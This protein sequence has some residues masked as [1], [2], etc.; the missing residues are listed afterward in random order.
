MTSRHIAKASHVAARDDR[1]GYDGMEMALH[2]TTAL[3][4]VILYALSQIWSSCRAGRRCGW[5]CSRCMS[6]WASCWQPGRAD[7]D[8]LAS[9]A[10]AAGRRRR[11]PD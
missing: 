6:R 4:V 2:W 8:R 7:A 11:P 10:R 9:G 3:L 5:G 1:V